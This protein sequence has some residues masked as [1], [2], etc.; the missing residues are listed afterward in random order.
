MTPKKSKRVATDVP[1]DVRPAEKKTWLVMLYISADS[2]LAN[3]AIESLKQLKPKTQ[4][5][6]P[7]DVIVAAQFAIGPPAGQQ[8]P[9]YVFDKSEGPDASIVQ[10]RKGI[11]DAPCNM[12]EQEALADFVDWAY[13]CLRPAEYHI[14]I[15]WG[16]G[17]E[18]LLLP[19]AECDLLNPSGNGIRPYLTPIEL[20]HALEDAGIQRRIPQKAS[21]TRETRDH[22]NRH[23][24]IIGFDACSMSM[25]EVAYEIR[26]L[27][28][29]MVAS[30]DDVPDLSFPYETLVHLIEKASD[31]RCLSIKSVTEYVNAYQD[32]IYAPRTDL[33]QV[34][35]SSFNL[36]KV[37]SVRKAVCELAVALLNAQSQCG[38]AEVLICCRERAQEFACGLYVD[39]FGFCTE[40]KGM[41]ESSNKIPP[42]ASKPIIHATAKIIDALKP[43]YNADQLL[44]YDPCKPDNNQPNETDCFILINQA[45]ARDR[46]H[47][48]SIYFPYLSDDDRGVIQQPLV[49]GGNDT[50]GAKGG[51]DTLGGK[52]S[53]GVLNQMACNILLCYRRQLIKDTE[54]YYCDLALSL[55]THWCRFIKCFWSCILAQYEPTLLDLKYSAQQCAMNL[56]SCYCLKETNSLAKG[57][58]C[59][60]PTLN[61][62]GRS[63]SRSRRRPRNC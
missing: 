6:I 31:P 55:D 38:L 35:L 56:S 19:S 39:L 12:T 4:K 41:L 37:D 43:C 52:G 15:L 60:D 29:F 32:Y 45:S 49:K 28:D 62:V 3:F 58:S 26:D 54:A 44:E 48:I 36:S 14:L 16:H 9:R 40:L 2:T 51:N 59:D 5:G 17:P 21:D 23:L 22:K 30:Q 34:T 20:R 1:H 53:P 33:D 42:A 8:I 47:G 50:L 13:S 57:L 61:S 11:L 10:Y 63:R 24:D 27:A 25:L 46:C 7:S 18:L